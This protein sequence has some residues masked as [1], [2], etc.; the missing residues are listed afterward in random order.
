MSADPT[1]PASPT[2]FAKPPKLR[3][4]DV[5][6]QQKLVSE[7]QVQQAL[8]EGKQTG[9][10]LGR[11]LIER[12]LVTEEAVVQAL[13]TQLRI[14]FVN[15]KTFPL[16]SDTVKLLPESP[17]RRHRAIVLEDKGEFCTVAVADPLDL[18]AYDE[19]VRLLRKPIQIAVAAESQ[20]PAAFDKHY[21]RNDEITGLAKA[22]EK[23]VGDAVDFGTLQASLGQEAAPVVRLLQSLF[24]DAVNVGASD[25]HLEP[26]ER[27]LLIRNRVDGV[28]QTQAQ[29]DKRIAAA[30]TQRLKLMASLDISE[31]RLPQ[32]GRFS[33]RL[34]DR[35]LD[36]RL[37]TLPSQHGESVVMRLL[38]QDSAVRRLDSIGMPS[39][40]L[41]RFTEILGR[42]SGMVLVTGPTGS[43]KT[44][45]LYAALAEVDAEQNKI[46]TVEDPVEY[47]LPGLTQVQVNDK[48][49]LTFARVLRA[50]LRQDPDVILVGEMRDPETAEIGLRAAMTGHM[51]LSTLHTKDAISTPFRLLDM[52]VPAFMVA[53]SLQAVIAQRL[54]RGVCEHCAE[55]HALTPQQQAW[56]DAVAGERAA[57]IAPK[58]GRGCTQCNSTGYTGRHGVY[59][60]L[61]MDADLTQ[62]A[63]QGDPTA[64]LAAARKRMAGRSLVDHALELLRLGRTSITE[65]LRMAS[66]VDNSGH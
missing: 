2:T 22:L 3:L 30:L 5:L 26:Q 7:A 19:L 8:E 49:E 46:I 20:L 1:A 55:P 37:S 28:L 18:F 56:L 43:G 64:F 65:A 59:E 39:A 61:E 53:T 12:G 63:T 60:M 29:A 16:R 36:V 35:T 38:G 62:A 51:V 13:A 66:D 34:K 58:R 9:K 44:T 50:C 48:I 45:T 6:V 11:L 4:G 32:D 24:E 41:R 57:G 25:V 23:D 47:R 14:P 40:M 21:R 42:V 33:L 52:G 17:A 15:L 31:K 54:V 27:E 10:R